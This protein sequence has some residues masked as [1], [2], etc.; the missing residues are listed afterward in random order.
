MSIL[1]FWAVQMNKIYII[2]MLLY[3]II[4]SFYFQLTSQISTLDD[5]VAA[6]ESDDNKNQ[7]RIFYLEED[8]L[9]VTNEGDQWN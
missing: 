7:M 4:I 6:I 8:M 3:I 9:A 2:C 5:R 1:R